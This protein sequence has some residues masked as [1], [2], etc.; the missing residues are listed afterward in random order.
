MKI[1]IIHA[2]IVVAG[3]C[4]CRNKQHEK[5]H[6]P[7]LSRTPLKE[8]KNTIAAAP[9]ITDPVCG[10]V[11]DSTWTDFS[12]VNGDTIWFCSEI[13]KKAYLANPKKYQAK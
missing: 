1:S 11:K 3:L 6:M 13:E 9:Q 8:K 5:A 2:A 10:M 4:A 12:A 7:A